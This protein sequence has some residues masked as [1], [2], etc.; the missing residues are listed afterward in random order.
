M[1][2]ISKIKYFSCP[3][4]GK[5]IEL[6][7]GRYSLY[8]HI[9][10]LAGKDPAHKD[11]KKINEKDILK[12]LKGEKELPYDQEIVDEYKKYSELRK[13]SNESEESIE[14]EEKTASHAFS[15]DYSIGSDDKI[16]TTASNALRNILESA[17]G[18]KSK[19]IEII[20]GQFHYENYKDID[21]LRKILS[22]N[23]V[24][25]M[26]IEWIID[27]YSKYI[28]LDKKQLEKDEINK[29][30]KNTKN[31]ID[32]IFN[33]EEERV[34]EKL[35]RQI[36]LKKLISKAKAMGIDLS[37]YG[38]EVSNVEEEDPIDW[39]EFPPD[40][41]HFIKMRTSKYAELIVKMQTSQQP[42]KEETIPWKN[43]Y[44][45]EVIEV[46]I[47]RY[48][49]YIQIT[50]EYKESQAKNKREETMVPWKNPY[51]GEIVMVPRSQYLH[52][53]TITAEKEKE[54]DE[55]KKQMM[56]IE[57]IKASFER[58]LDDYRKQLSSLQSKLN[59]KEKEELYGYLSQLQNELKK[60]QNRDE[61]EE[62]LKVKQKIDNLAETMG[63]RSGDVSVNDQIILEETKLKYEAISQ[64]FSVF[65]KKIDEAVS[66]G[67]KVDKLIEIFAPIIQDE[68]RRLSDQ[69]RLHQI[70]M[71]RQG[72]VP[73]EVSRSEEEINQILN[74]LNTTTKERPS[75]LQQNSHTEQS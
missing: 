70:Q 7:K 10:N 24:P 57:E 59:E 64:I 30:S 52:F 12:W 23:N 50:K 39:F 1:T 47:S 11:Y 15:E 61:L 4:C 2:G 60:V 75:T 31:S 44:T 16:I 56:K 43:P 55:T 66:K 18:P 22:M 8:G 20:M 17:L 62:F 33:E 49:H 21:A 9:L 14:N 13:R 32:E 69:R 3:V 54:D 19:K 51:M 53:L 35:E 46:P 71:E 58:Q 42:K 45:N 74:R 36:K 38:L 73:R 5:P 29:E 72:L 68:A 40:S 65:V 25:D 27:K 6:K 48:E 41:G 26:K 67:S 37:Q 28:G 63:L 34:M